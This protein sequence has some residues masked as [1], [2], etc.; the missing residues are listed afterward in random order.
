MAKSLL[1][2]SELAPFS[3]CARFPLFSPMPMFS[4]APASAGTSPVGVMPFSIPRPALTSPAV[5]PVAAATPALTRF[6]S[7]PSPVGELRY[8]VPPLISA[9]FAPDSSAVPRSAPCSKAFP[10]FSTPPPTALVRYAGVP[11]GTIA[12]PMVVGMLP[13]VLKSELMPPEPPAEL[14]KALS[15]AA[16]VYAPAVPASAVPAP[17]SAPAPSASAPIPPVPTATPSCTRV[18]KRELFLSCAALSTAH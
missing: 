2:V 18:L 1:P 6:G 16:V 10:V 14:A 9:P 5:F 11:A 15:A 8:P 7:N 4:A 12:E 13:M 17:A 3:T